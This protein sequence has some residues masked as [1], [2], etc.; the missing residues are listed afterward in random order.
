MDLVLNWALVSIY[1]LSYLQFT[2]FYLVKLALIRTLLT[3]LPN[4]GC[5]SVMVPRLKTGT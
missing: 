3:N 1:V 4:G 2:V 5:A